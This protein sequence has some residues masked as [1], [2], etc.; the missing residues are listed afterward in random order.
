VKLSDMPTFDQVLGGQ[1]SDPRFRDEWE[2]T[3]LV[4]EVAAALVGHRSEHGLTQAGLARRAG[5]S[6]STIARL[7]AADHEPSPAVLT[8]LATSLGL[9]F[10][11]PDHP[12]TPPRRGPMAVPPAGH[13][14]PPPPA[15]D[16]MPSAAPGVPARAPE[17]RPPGRRRARPDAVSRTPEPPAGQPISSGYS[18]RLTEEEQRSLT[19]RLLERFPFA[20]PADFR[21]KTVQP[22]ADDGDP[23]HGTER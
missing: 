19:R 8:G 20:S 23:P 14:T 16:L 2:R 4:R 21:A 17:V 6:R 22:A 13:T 1:L 10:H 7:E 5:V 18:R 12:E 15:E 11:H 9:S 3:R